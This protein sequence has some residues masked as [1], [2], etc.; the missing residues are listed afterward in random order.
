VKETANHAVLFE[1]GTYEKCL[2]EIPTWKLITPSIVTERMRVRSPDDGDCW[3]GEERTGKDN[4]GH[5]V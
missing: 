3:E 1:K 5:Y 2:K 4:L